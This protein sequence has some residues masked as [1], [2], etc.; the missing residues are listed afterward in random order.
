MTNITSKQSWV[1][2]ET[3]EEYTTWEY[4]SEQLQLGL[5]NRQH[6]AAVSH[7]R[8]A[9]QHPQI[10][11]TRDAVK[12]IARCQYISWSSAKIT[13]KRRALFRCSGALTCTDF[14]FYLT[15]HRPRTPFYKQAPTIFWFFFF[16]RTRCQ[17][18]HALP[19][20]V[21]FCPNMFHYPSLYARKIESPRIDPWTST[22]LLATEASVTKCP[23]IILKHPRP[24]FR[25][26]LNLPFG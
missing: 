2:F 19:G 5:P 1:N 4:L 7:A 18:K 12:I 21:I 11:P 16:R 14:P 8:T 3:F 25:T 20:H 23:D 15:D 26:D 24:C 10:R 22:T 6:G 9:H 17:A 13:I